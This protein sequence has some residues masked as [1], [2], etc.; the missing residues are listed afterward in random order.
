MTTTGDPFPI[1]VMWDDDMKRMKLY[2]LMLQRAAQY[3]MYLGQAFPT[4]RI[5]GLL[6]LISERVQYNSEVLVFQWSI[7]ILSDYL[8]EK[9]SS[10]FSNTFLWLQSLDFRQ[11]DVHVKISSKK[12]QCCTLNYKHNYQHNV[13]P[14][15]TW[16]NYCPPRICCLHV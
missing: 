5:V 10:S 9:Y 7:P 3:S 11:I 8:W 14:S 16:T 1:R 4:R 13:L 6:T 15:T 2:N 12:I